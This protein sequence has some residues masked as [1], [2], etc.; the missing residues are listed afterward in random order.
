MSDQIKKEDIEIDFY[1]VKSANYRTFFIDGI[2]GGLTSHGLLSCECFT[3]RK[4]IPTRVRYS[5]K[6]NGEM[7][8]EIEREGDQ[9]GFLREIECGLIMNINTAKSLVVWLN[10][11]IEEHS[12]IFKEN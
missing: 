11:K 8:D 10:K 9:A 6:H 7:G 3:E 4:S 12:D 1:H 2:F 5:I